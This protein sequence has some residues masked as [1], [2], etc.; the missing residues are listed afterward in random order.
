MFFCLVYGA[1]HST[2]HAS[3]EGHCL[4]CSGSHQELAHNQL[5]FFCYLYGACH[6]TSHASGEGGHGYGDGGTCP[7]RPHCKMAH[8]I[9]RAMP[10][11]RGRIAYL[12][13]PYLAQF[14]AKRKNLSFFARFR[15]KYTKIHKNYHTEEFCRLFRII[16]Y[17]FTSQ[18]TILG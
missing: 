13:F 5:V 17:L 2:S 4:L 11:A 16:L 8:A 6:S 7:L 15:P 18:T 10:A 1:C 12:L 14:H 9:L 3:G